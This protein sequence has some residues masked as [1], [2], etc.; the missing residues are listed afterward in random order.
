MNSYLL[1][2]YMTI[3]GLLG[4]AIYHNEPRFQIAIFLLAIANALFLWK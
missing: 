1:S 3:A 4:M 2:Y